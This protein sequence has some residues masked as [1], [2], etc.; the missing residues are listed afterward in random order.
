MSAK[1]KTG[2]APWWIALGVGTVLILIPEPATTGAGVLIVLGT[3]GV[4][5]GEAATAAL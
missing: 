1:K 4:K 5:A 2:V 3:L